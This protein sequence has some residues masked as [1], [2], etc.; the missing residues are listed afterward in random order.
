MTRPEMTRQHD[1][2]DDATDEFELAPP[3]KLYAHHR[4]QLS[5]MMD[6]ELS[7]DAAKFMLRRLEHDSGLSGCWER[8]QV[9]GDVLR[10]QRSSLLP[11]DFPQRVA[12]A[13]AAG[14][15]AGVRDR[16]AS[17][18]PRRLRWG[19]SAA[20]A[21]S[22]AAVA[23][24]LAR[25][26]PGEVAPATPAEPARVA[27]SQGTG[28]GGPASPGPSAAG[29]GL[30]RVASATERAPA[31]PATPAAETVAAAALASAVAVSEVPR[32]ATARRSSGQVQR[33]AS[34]LR[35]RNVPEAVVAASGAQPVLASLPAPLPPMALSDP[36]ATQPIAPAR[37]WPRA[38]LPALGNGEV[39]SAGY[40]PAA[41]SFEPF[42]PRFAPPA[43]EGPEATS[44]PA[45]GAGPVGPADGGPSDDAAP[46]NI[47]PAQ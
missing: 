3:D 40:G 43:P 35:A 29:P 14:D 46:G 10:G 13:I 4:R 7:P 31:L 38:A 37:P 21:A 36:F 45:D 6:G 26:M 23:F 1:I 11:A 44:A 8:W 5:A 34:N 42:V 32:R 18:R 39:F 9:C 25:Q 47:S 15:Q 20:L 17:A 30:S 2:P 28:A 19:G 27:A 22:V 16:T 12:A 41:S 24:L 33:A